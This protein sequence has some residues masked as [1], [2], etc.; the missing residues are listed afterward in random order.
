MLQLYI[1]SSQVVFAYNFAQLE[2][3]DGLLTA[4]QSSH[5][6]CRSAPFDKNYHP[7]AYI[8]ILSSIMEIVKSI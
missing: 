7:Q 2:L 1:F 8:N 5:L 4:D 6:H 3:T